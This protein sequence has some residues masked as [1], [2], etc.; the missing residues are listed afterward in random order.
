MKQLIAK[1][2][3]RRNKVLSGERVANVASDTDV[4]IMLYNL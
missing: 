3:V 2:S 1:F 4:L